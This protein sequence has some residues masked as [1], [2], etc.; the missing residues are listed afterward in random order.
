MCI[1]SEVKRQECAAIC[2]NVRERR[3]TIRD[4]PPP[5]KKPIGVHS[6]KKQTLGNEARL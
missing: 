1:S 3:K 2:C 5:K 6:L 4:P